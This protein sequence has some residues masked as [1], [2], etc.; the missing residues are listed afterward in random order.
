MMKRLTI[1]LALLFSVSSAQ[2]IVIGG[3]AA[4]PKSMVSAS[5]FVTPPAT[6][7]VTPPPAPT[8]T[9]PAASTPAP[10]T[11][12]PIPEQHFVFFTEESKTFLDQSANYGDAPKSEDGPNVSSVP[13]PAALPLMATALGIFGITRRRKTF[14]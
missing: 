13:V 4:K 5:T 8:P 3:A 10:Q 6:S 1:T 12:T 2:A 11:S 7:V 9:P 14:K